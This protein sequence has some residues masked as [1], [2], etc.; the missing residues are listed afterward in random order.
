[1]P[2]SSVEARRYAEAAFAVAVER[3]AVDGWLAHLDALAQAYANPEVREAVRNPSLAANVRGSILA[4]VAGVELSG[5]ESNLVGLLLQRRRVGLLP[6]LAAEFHRLVDRR[7]GVTGAS[8]TSAA[9]LTP[10]ELRALTDRLTELTSGP[11]RVTTR[12]DSALLGG[13]VVRVGDRLYDGSVRGR[14]ERLRSRLVAG[15]L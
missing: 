4:R 3:G 14:L 8:V 13:V 7:S 11:V 9:P 10:D 12:I 6:L 15:A 5:P 2:Q 1:M